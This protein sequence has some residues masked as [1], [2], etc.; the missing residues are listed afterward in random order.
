MGYQ[1][2]F[3]L[4]VV[5]LPKTDLGVEACRREQPK[6]RNRQKVHNLRLEVLVV[7][8]T[9]VLLGGIV[10]FLH[11]DLLVLLDIVHMDKCINTTSEEPIN[12]MT[13]P[14]DAQLDLTSVNAL[15]MHVIGGVPEVDLEVIGGGCNKL[16]LG[17]LNVHVVGGNESTTVTR[18]LLRYVLNPLARARV[19]HFETLRVALHDQ[20]VLKLA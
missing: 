4:H 20:Q 2:L 19:V 18:L 17:V 15:T 7:V 9:L 8:H 12:T 13:A 5:H 16:H 6:L 3:W 11:S 1:C 10:T 14:L